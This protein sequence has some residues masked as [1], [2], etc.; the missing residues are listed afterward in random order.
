[1]LL[2]LFTGTAIG[3]G[4]L[5]AGVPNVELMTLVVAL[6]G[7][8]L[9]WRLGAVCGA[10]AA[11]V[12][13]LGSP[14]GLPAPLLLAG[15]AA[16]L[17][18]AGVTGAVL[19]P[20]VRSRA[21]ADRR[22]R[23]LTAAGAAGLLATLSYDLLTNLAIMGMLDL[24]PRV[25]L[26]G[27]VP[28]TL[29]HVAFN[30]SVFMLLFPLLVERLHGLAE[31]PL[32]GQG[33][34]ASLLV[35]GFLAIMFPGLPALGQQAA[36]A[37]DTTGLPAPADSVSVAAMEQGTGP[38][39]QLGWRRP[40][41]EPYAP[42]VVQWL[43]WRSSWVTVRD[44]GLGSAAVI[45]G[46]ASTSPNPAFE[47]DGVPVGTGHALADDPWLVTNQGL[48]VS[49]SGTG[50]DL[51][52]GHDGLVALETDDS[53]P[54]QA[55]SIYRGIKGPH[56]T[57][58]RG[59][60]VL[61]PRAAWRVGFEFDE[62]IDNEAWNFTGEPEGIFRQDTEFPG[63]AKVRFS[64]T[65]MTRNL[66]VD[67]SVTLE[68]TTG[69]QTKDS[70]PAWNAEHRE[71]W[72]AGAAA[73]VR[74]RTGSWL[75]RTTLFWNSRDVRWGDRPTSQGPA[76]GSRTLETVRE[77]VSIDLLSWPV[78]GDTLAGDHARPRPKWDKAV[79]QGTTSLGLRLTNWEVADTG[80][81]WLPESAAADACG[82]GQ[83]AHLM[84]RAGRPVAGARLLGAVTST[85]DSRGGLSD[86]GELALAHDG[87]RHGWRVSLGRSNRAPR[88]DELLTPVDRNIAGRVVTIMPDAD[89]DHERTWRL[90][91]LVRTRLLGFDL[92]AEGSLRRLR[93]GITYVADP[94]QPDAGRWAN[95][96]EL[97]SSRVTG[98]VGRQGRFLGWVRATVEG[99]WQSFDEISGQAALLP[100]DQYLRLVLMWENH[101]F[102]E[103]GILQIALFS[104]RRAAMADPWDPTRQESLPE[105]TWHD[106]VLGFRL[107]GANLSLAIRNLTDQQVPL[108]AGSLSH[109][110]EMDLRLHWG[111]YY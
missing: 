71:I 110:R 32:R 34:A 22:W 84:A 66:D 68:Y 49:R 58:H 40:L 27:A 21:A 96:L 92:A 35:V 77:G 36:A 25:I 111:F 37:A 23:R 14:L 55:Y 44:G 83:Q 70:L 85:W 46:E 89:L 87:D 45:L 88:S 51:R 52:T 65:R 73:I 109:G 10:V 8:T 42:S 18:L 75:S 13:S 9:R 103:D 30:V 5:L 4:Y 94:G 2:G 7:A 69:R 93:D 47:R 28:Y 97:D 90:N 20:V 86:G 39:A 98:S 81:A 50:P 64:R 3:A 15:Q 41:W 74:A 1:V 59:I 104:T 12:Y 11:V 108:S 80:A 102:R 16:G 56:E 107:V 105:L 91:G 48:R 82:Q 54:Q 17:A 62:S 29:I 53:H 61:S 101:F 106:L 95:A 26:T 100:P 63:H 38:R 24:D 31:P 33:P 60:S 57:Y 79:E 78:V 6:G 67:N 72:D 99:T 43:E 19:G 76:A